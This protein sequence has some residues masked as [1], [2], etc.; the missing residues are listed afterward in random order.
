M[1]DKF[2]IRDTAGVNQ[3]YQLN[4]IDPVSYLLKYYQDSQV[5]EAA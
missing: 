2:E 3:I 5:G 4:S 1:P